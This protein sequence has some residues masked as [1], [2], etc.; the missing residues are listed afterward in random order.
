MTLKNKS[1]TYYRHTRENLGVGSTRKFQKITEEDVRELEYE[2]DDEKENG[3]DFKDF[4]GD[5]N[6]DKENNAIRGSAEWLRLLSPMLITKAL[7]AMEKSNTY[8]ST[9]PR[10][11]SQPTKSKTKIAC[12]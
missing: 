7:S 5:G 3:T 12:K 1:R 9:S 8:S 6:G 11:K 2:D 4:D 10:K